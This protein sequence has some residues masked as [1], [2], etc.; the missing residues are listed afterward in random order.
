M[1]RIIAEDDDF[2]P[3]TV[4]DRLDQM[5]GDLTGSLLKDLA[6]R[7]KNEIAAGVKDGLTSVQI[8]KNLQSKYG[9]FKNKTTQSIVAR[10][11]LHA[12]YTQG[13]MY[14]SLMD[15]DIV[16]FRF[17]NPADSRSTTLCKHLA[18][19][20]IEKKDIH[21][22]IPPLHWGCRSVLVPLYF[23]DDINPE[24]IITPKVRDSAEFRKNVTN[25]LDKNFTEFTTMNLKK[26]VEETE[27]ARMPKA[28]EEIQRQTDATLD[29]L[30]DVLGRESLP[31]NDS[32]SADF[33]VREAILETLRRTMPEEKNIKKTK[34]YLKTDAALNKIYEAHKNKDLKGELLKHNAYDIARAVEKTGTRIFENE[35]VKA[36]KAGSIEDKSLDFYLDGLN[37]G[38]KI[39]DQLKSQIKNILRQYGRDPDFF[40]LVLNDLRR[41]A[42]AP[43][44]SYSDYHALDEDLQNVFDEY[45]SEFFKSVDRGAKVS[46]K[47]RAALE[48]AVI[49]T[50]VRHPDYDRFVDS[51]PFATLNDVAY[52]AMIKH[53]NEAIST[54]TKNEFEANEIR[55]RI[56]FAGVERI[57]TR[58][59]AGAVESIRKTL[60]E[61]LQKA[62]SGGIINYE[63]SYEFII[64]LSDEK[65]NKIRNRSD[66]IEKISNNMGFDEQVI[67][68]IKEHVFYNEHELS[69]GKKRFDSDFDMAMAWERM[70]EGENIKPSDLILLNHEIYER[71]LMKGKGLSYYEAHILANEKYNW[72][73]ALLKEN[74]DEK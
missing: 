68:E 20:V 13:A 62:L 43:L 45:L 15:E 59:A 32:E 64:K 42:T 71:E 30:R 67:K 31:R 60:H 53:L 51:V 72:E 61:N 18:G 17:S 74:G 33:V 54:V 52:A 26:A 1:A 9:D 21:N 73:A 3:K 2:I 8:G 44:S 48:K 47:D 11:L 7:F 29:S 25:K 34:D 22:Y 10:T 4:L 5:A 19:K 6:G 66:D 12:A 41:Q 46:F 24:K 16:A 70:T 35:A 56:L 55:N 49:N 40:N 28:T 37:G 39:S 38:R 27:E 57:D 23:N 36:F 63:Q 69:D 65:Y 58:S 50:F 14:D